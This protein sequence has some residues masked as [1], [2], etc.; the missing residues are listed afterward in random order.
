MWRLFANPLCISAAQE[1]DPSFFAK[2]SFLYGSPP[3]ASRAIFSLRGEFISLFIMLL[4]RVQQKITV[5]GNIV[6]VYYIKSGQETLSERPQ[7]SFYVFEN[8]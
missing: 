1:M 8:Y 6:Q 5:T 2:K 4:L 3:K 7:F